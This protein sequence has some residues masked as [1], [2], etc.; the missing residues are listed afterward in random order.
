MH[1]LSFSY[2]SKAST[3]VAPT[4]NCWILL[5]MSIKLYFLDLT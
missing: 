3:A 2:N 5:S 1:Y 4:Y